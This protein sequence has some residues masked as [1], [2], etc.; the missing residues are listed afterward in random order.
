MRLIKTL[1]FEMLDGRLYFT[2]D[3]K[4]REHTVHVYLTVPIITNKHYL[5]FISNSIESIVSDGHKKKKKNL[6]EG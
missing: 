5:C 3:F 4:C 1:Y 6:P 2:A